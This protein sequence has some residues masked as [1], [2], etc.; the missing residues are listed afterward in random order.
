MRSNKNAQTAEHNEPAKRNAKPVRR[1]EC[2][3]LG[4]AGKLRRL[5]GNAALKG[6]SQLP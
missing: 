3:T 1:E 5:C 4:L 6:F 2:S